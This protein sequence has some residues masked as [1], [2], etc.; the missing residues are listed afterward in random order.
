ME[1]KSCRRILLL[2]SAAKHVRE[3]E[4][5][6]DADPTMTLAELHVKRWAQPRGSGAKTSDVVR[7]STE[8]S[9]PRDA[10]ERSAR[11]LGTRHRRVSSRRFLGLAAGDNEW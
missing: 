11:S 5:V 9:D 10:A 7:W 2:A 4:G 1:R 8:C 3:S 6:Q